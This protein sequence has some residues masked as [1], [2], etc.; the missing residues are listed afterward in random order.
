MVLVQFT[1]SV[2]GTALSIAVF[3][4]L[5]WTRFQS[6]ESQ[7]VKE[8][9]K[10][11]FRRHLWEAQSQNSSQTIGVAELSERMTSGVNRH[12]NA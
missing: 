9:A 11:G 2:F 12:P 5:F 4:S 10:D 7:L 3:D 6:I 8:S 1:A